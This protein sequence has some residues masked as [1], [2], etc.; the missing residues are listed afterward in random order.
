M[1]MSG[2]FK[3]QCHG[4]WKDSPG[5]RPTRVSWGKCPSSFLVPFSGVQ[6][7]VV[8]LGGITKRKGVSSRANLLISVKCLWVTLST[9]VTMPGQCPL[10][11]LLKRKSNKTKNKIH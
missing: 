5:S 1:M 6:T 2:A 7:R 4:G 3:G 10:T 8:A 9:L 11:I